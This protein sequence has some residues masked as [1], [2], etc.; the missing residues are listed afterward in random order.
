MNRV[1]VC[2]ARVLA[3]HVLLA[4]GLVLTSCAAPSN[5]KAASDGSSVILSWQIQSQEDNYGFFLE[6]G[7][8]EQ[9]PFTV[10]TPKIIAGHGTT[11]VPHTY[12]F[13]DHEVT[14]GRTYY[15]RLWSI[16]YQNQKKLEG[17]IVGKAKTDE[18]RKAAEATAD[19]AK[20]PAGD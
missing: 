5:G 18:D 7:D 16:S 3:A 2:F 14:R 8:T 13:V 9:G 4:A 15:Y 17:M 12:E 1:C 20:P 11:N 19:P 10:V 6:R